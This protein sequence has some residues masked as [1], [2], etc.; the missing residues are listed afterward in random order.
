M[1][2]PSLIRAVVHPEK[3]RQQANGAAGATFYA[4]STLSTSGY[5]GQAGRGAGTVTSKRRNIGIRRP[6]RRRCRELEPGWPPRLARSGNVARA[7]PGP[8]LPGA[9]ASTY[10]IGEAD[11]GHR[12]RVVATPSDSDGGGISVD[13]A[14]TAV[15]VAP[16]PTLT[17]LATSLSVAAGGSVP[18]PISVAGFDP[19]DKVSVTVAPE[20]PIL[21]E[22]L[23]VLR[24]LFGISI[25]GLVTAHLRS[26]LYHRVVRRDRIMMRMITG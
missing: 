3:A 16:P 17:I 11:E 14:A 15:V 21:A 7:A 5:F 18:L 8:T 2:H 4:E 10:V 26:A 19:D 12:L 23:F 22:K 6:A 20:D 25:A 9:T 24:D 13:S 1:C